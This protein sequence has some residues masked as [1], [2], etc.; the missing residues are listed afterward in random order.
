MNKQSE[1]FVNELIEQIKK[2]YKT[3][4][5]GYSYNVK[6][7]VIEIWHNS[8]DLECC[9]VEFASF[10]GKLIE[11][12]LFRN[13]IYNFSF[14]FDYDKAKAIGL[15]YKSMNSINNEPSIGVYKDESSE[16]ITKDHIKI[17]PQIGEI[18]TKFMFSSFT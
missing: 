2:V 15:G 6:E 12:K 13:N 17:R 18:K 11:E 16:L 14:G 8:F 9:D 1:L 4:I 5:I 10:A 7:D 3:L